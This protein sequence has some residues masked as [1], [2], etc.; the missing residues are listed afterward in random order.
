MARAIFSIDSRIT[1]EVDVGFWSASVE[2]TAV[3]R[4]EVPVNAEL[5]PGTLTVSASAAKGTA[6]AE[7]VFSSPDPT[8]PA[9]VVTGFCTTEAAC[10]TAADRSSVRDEDTR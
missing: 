2:A 4:P 7:S 8:E 6:R 1:V 3:S 9:S 5:G 10:C